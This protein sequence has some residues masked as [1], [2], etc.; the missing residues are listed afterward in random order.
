M[1]QPVPS[2]AKKEMNGEPR[3]ANAKVTMISTM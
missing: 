2:T 3:G 1:M